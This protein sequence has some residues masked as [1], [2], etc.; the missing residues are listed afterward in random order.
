MSLSNVIPVTLDDLL[1]QVVLKRT[2]GCRLVTITCSHLGDAHDILYHFDSE[3]RL[4]HLRLRLE[5]GQELPSISSLYFSA[6]IVENEI[7]DMFGICVKNLALD[8]QG[9]LLLTENAPRAPLNKATPGIGLDVRVSA[10]AAATEA[11]KA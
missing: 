5:P 8:F 11:P 6:L 4:S 3:Q 1:Q 10:P 9:R 2:Q 7:Q